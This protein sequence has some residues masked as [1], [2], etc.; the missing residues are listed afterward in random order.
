MSTGTIKISSY[1]DLCKIGNDEAYPFDGHYE[2]TCDIDASA[3]RE[4]EEGF[5]PI[6]GRWDYSRRYESL[7][8]AE[9]SAN[10]LLALVSIFGAGDKY[11]GYVVKRCGFSGKYD[12]NDFFIKGLY[13]NCP[14]GDA[15]L[16]WQVSNGA[17]IS[18]V[19]LVDAEIIGGGNVGGLAA[20]SGGFIDNCSFS[21]IVKCLSGNGK[22]GGLVG[23]CDGGKIIKCKV[24]ATVTGQCSVG[25]LV[26]SAGCG[27][28][29]KPENSF[30]ECSFKGDI[31]G[32]ESIGGLVGSVSPVCSFTKCH[33]SGKVS[34]EKH[35]GGL[36]GYSS[37]SDFDVIFSECEFSGEFRGDSNFGLIGYESN[38]EKTT[39]KSCCFS[40]GI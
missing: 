16:F 18:E 15:G 34:G 27:L 37:S 39:I 36:A 38:K 9:K 13:V 33:S 30:T 24:N 6:W 4:S 25:G 22:L 3:S 1:E 40:Q 29:K 10:N 8:D 17:E 14:K 31:S 23:R 2:Q 11:D 35:V 19:N 28:D 12:G 5:K 7:S 26:G 20:L 21:G 32:K